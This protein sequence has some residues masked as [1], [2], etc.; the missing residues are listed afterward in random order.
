MHSLLFFFLIPDNQMDIVSFF[1]PSACQLAFLSKN[2]VQVKVSEIKFTVCALWSILLRK[3]LRPIQ[4]RIG[5][6]FLQ[7]NPQ[8]FYFINP[9]SSKPNQKHS[10]TLSDV[11][12]PGGATLLQQ[13]VE[14]PIE[15]P[16]SP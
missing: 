15:E 13:A 11:D 16:S 1:C 5:K 9:H 12:V 4:K 10:T 2:L 14:S 8:T 7:T 3:L 6:T